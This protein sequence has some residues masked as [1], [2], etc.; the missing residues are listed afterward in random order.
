MVTPD[1]PNHKNLEDRIKDF[2]IEHDFIIKSVTYHELYS[3]EMK[4][5][6]TQI[7]TPTS[8]YIR[9]RPDGIAV[10]RRLPIVFEW[11]AKTREDQIGKDC[12]LEIFPIIS[13]LV[14]ARSL[15]VRCL[16][17]WHHI[18]T[19]DECG[20]WFQDLPKISSIHFPDRWQGRE[21]RGFQKLF[22]DFFPKVRVIPTEQGIGSGDPYVVIDRSEIKKLSH[23]QTLILEIIER[24]ERRNV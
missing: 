21:R 23:W 24:E 11:D 2:L 7:Y 14:N 20:F 10:H 5:R 17:C 6:L 12:L 8:L 18:Y 22:D 9:T 15:G 13:H 16:Y 1:D 19:G 3:E 4:N